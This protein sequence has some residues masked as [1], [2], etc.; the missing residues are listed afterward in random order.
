MQCEGTT[1]P[2]VVCQGSPSSVSEKLTNKPPSVK[3]DGGLV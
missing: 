1:V 2:R 3:C